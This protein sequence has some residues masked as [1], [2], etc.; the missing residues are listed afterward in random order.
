LRRLLRATL[1]LSFIAGH[2]VRGDELPRITEI[3]IRTGNVFTKS[4]EE[5]SFFPYGL[6][7]AIHTVTREN[8]IRKELL[9]AV[10]DPLDLDRLAETERNLRATGLF[11]WVLVRAEATRVFV[12]TGDTWTL[13]PRGSF[14]DKGGVVTYSAGIEEDNLAG[15]GRSLFL[16]YDKGTQRIERSLSFSDPNF[17]LP[18]ALLKLSASDLSDGGGVA[19]EFSRPFFALD[20]LRDW[21]LLYQQ[22]RFVTTLYAGGQESAKY[23]E[24]VRDFQAGLGLRVRYTGDR[25]WRLLG[26][27][28]WSDT[29]LFPGR[30][31]PPP[32][33]GARR[34]LFLSSGLQTE[35]REWIQRENAEQM[36]RVEDF[37]LAP[38]GAVE[39]GL[40]P[41]VLTAQAAARFRVRGSVGGL[42][43]SGFW[44][45]NVAGETR[46]QD[47]PRGATVTAD[48]RGYLLRDMTTLVGHLGVLSGSRLDPEAQI[49]LDGERGVRGYR[50]HAASGTGRFVMNLELRE[51]FFPDVLNLVSFGAVAFIDSGLSWGPPD[52]SWTLAD[53]GVGLRFGLSRAAK[54]TILRLDVSKAFLPD[55]RGRAGWLLSFSS[56]Q[57]F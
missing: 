29:E 26:S 8:L 55:P 49:E 30:L 45:A 39:I 50:L 1:L 14:G 9:F 48:A 37:N 47:G 24:R 36:D 33:S 44:V 53:A 54:N 51:E 12:E 27:V 43:P 3:V 35:G 42:F 25:A 32:P 22:S 52:G 5:K 31:G 15:T 19:G 6:A 40:S 41:A 21:D 57:A 34:F 28:E 2:P 20:T 10:G 18:Y 11:R 46:Y 7:N 17:I 16:N 4:E 38:G 13:L 23:R 56:G